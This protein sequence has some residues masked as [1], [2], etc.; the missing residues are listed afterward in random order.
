VPRPAGPRAAPSSPPCQAAVAAPAQVI[1]PAGLARPANWHPLSL[2]PFIPQVRANG[3]TVLYHGALAASA[4]TFVGHYPWF[5]T[6]NYLNATLPRYEDDLLMK[7]AR[8]AARPR[9]GLGRGLC[10]PHGWRPAAAGRPHGH[11]VQPARPPARLPMSQRC[12]RRPSPA[13][14]RHPASPASQPRLSP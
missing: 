1:S 3:P 7:L 6:Y 13:L 12:P 2:I 4:A 5:A 9:L 14:P 11:S 8:W 10:T